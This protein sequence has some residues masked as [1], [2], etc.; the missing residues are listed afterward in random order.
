MASP[1]DVTSSQTTARSAPDSAP[2][3]ALGVL[4]SETRATSA[5]AKQDD[6]APVDDTSSVFLTD[7]YGR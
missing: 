7:T 6:A 4:D 2:F 5:A 3:S 1:A